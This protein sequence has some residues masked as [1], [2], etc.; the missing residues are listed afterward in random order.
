MEPVQCRFHVASAPL[1]VCDF[2]YADGLITSSE[3]WHLSGLVI[4]LETNPEDSSW[5]TLGFF[6]SDV[7]SRLDKTQ[8]RT[9]FTGHVDEPV[10][11]SCDEPVHW[12]C[13]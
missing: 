5:D 3:E 9:L 10:H 4:W 1:A 6:E 13:G 7:C 8:L 12:S 11:W 2:E